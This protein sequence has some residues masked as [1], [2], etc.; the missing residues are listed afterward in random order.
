MATDPVHLALY[1][2]LEAL[3]D[4]LTGEIVDGQ[5]HATPRPAP[6]RSPP[7]RSAGS[8]TRRFSAVAV[9]PAAGGSSTSRRFTSFAGSS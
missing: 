6:P 2:A 3:S 1:A 8:C 5:L 4:A 9:V 7:R